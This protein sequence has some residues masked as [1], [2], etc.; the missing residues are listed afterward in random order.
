M[1][2]LSGPGGL[3]LCRAEPHAVPQCNVST[4]QVQHP[5]SQ[6]N[7]KSSGTHSTVHSVVDSSAVDQSHRV[8]GNH[9]S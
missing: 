6:V 8:S 1:V 4:L 2:L 7:N 3:I 5:L 9:N